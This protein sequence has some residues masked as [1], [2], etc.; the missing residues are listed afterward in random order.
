MG[1]EARAMKPK[2]A[3]GVPSYEKAAWPSH[4]GEARRP[5]A[6]VADLAT[7]LA[8][9]IAA[10][11]L[12]AA[13]GMILTRV[14]PLAVPELLS[15]A[16]LRRDPVVA[17]A[18]AVTLFYVIATGLLVAATARQLRDGRSRWVKIFVFLIAL[19]PVAVSLAVTPILALLCFTD[20]AMVLLPG[21]L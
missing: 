16:I 18:L 2:V 11:A 20:A 17:V 8:Q 9:F 14:D 1:A 13:P 6:A 4:D 5:A 19:A 12:W 21:L 10:L 7:A 3:A 15:T